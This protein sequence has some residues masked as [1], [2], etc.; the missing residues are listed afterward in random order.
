ML[1][2]DVP[3][4]TLLVQRLGQQTKL[5]VATVSILYHGLGL[6]VFLKIRQNRR[7]WLPTSSTLGGLGYIGAVKRYTGRC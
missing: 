5:H 1:L 6:T 7:A 4:L 2:P 3:C